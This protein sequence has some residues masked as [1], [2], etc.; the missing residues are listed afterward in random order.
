MGGL[1]CPRLNGGTAGW[2]DSGLAGVVQAGERADGAET[3]WPVAAWWHHGR[4]MVAAWW[5]CGGGVVA[6]RRNARGVGLA[7]E[8]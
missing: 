7:S 6:V 4:S 8:Q 5:Q 2:L 1:D 3:D